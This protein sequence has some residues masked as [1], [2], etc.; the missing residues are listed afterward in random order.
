MNKNAQNRSVMK[1]HGKLERISL[2]KK[3][4]KKKQKNKKTGKTRTIEKE[5]D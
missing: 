4:Q 3:F 1:L 5:V 2:R